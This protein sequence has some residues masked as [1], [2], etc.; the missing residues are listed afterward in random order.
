MNTAQNISRD[1]AA[2]LHKCQMVQAA[3]ILKHGRDF[4]FVRRLPR[5]VK[6]GEI[7]RCF[8]HAL[9]IVCANP[10]RFF[11][12]EGYATAMTNRGVPI[13]PCEHAWICDRQGR[14][15]DPTWWNGRDYFGVV[16][17][18]DFVVSVVM[19]SACEGVLWNPEDEFRVATGAD[20]P[21]FVELE[22]A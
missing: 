6:R 9:D 5:S 4:T 22:A 11:Y 12:C 2:M 19:R 8:K 15:F 3:F 7:K 13:Y 18:L 1:Y 14:A 16:F 20:C 17:D 21:R 10:N